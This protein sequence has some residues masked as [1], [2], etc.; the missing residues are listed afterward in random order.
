MLQ[1]LADFANLEVIRAPEPDMT[2]TGAAYLAG[3]SV[4]YWQDRNQLQEIYSSLNPKHF[5]PQMERQKRI[6]KVARWKKAL[7]AILSID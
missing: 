6:T 3:L 2:A 7:E 5:Y 1:C 4:G